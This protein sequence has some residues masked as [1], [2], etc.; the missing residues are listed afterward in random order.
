MFVDKRQD[1]LLTH[2]HVGDCKG[3]RA[4]SDHGNCATVLEF[5]RKFDTCDDEDYLFDVRRVSGLLEH[6][7]L[8]FKTRP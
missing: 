8:V 2:A 3:N 4:E 7:K 5:Q 6:M 1:Y